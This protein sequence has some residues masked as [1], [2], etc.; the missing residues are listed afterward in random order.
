M[1]RR[2]VIRTCWTAASRTMILM[3][4]RQLLTAP[5]WQH[6]K[7]LCQKPKTRRSALFLSLSRRRSRGCR[8]FFT[9]RRA[10]PLSKSGALRAT[11]HKAWRVQA[12]R[13]WLG[14]GG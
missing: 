3:R 2:I 10:S 12:R 9:L 5:V 11:L 1:W 4:G 13:T 14:V 6:R 7:K 8:F